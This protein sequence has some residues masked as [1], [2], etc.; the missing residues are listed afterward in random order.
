MSGES[1]EVGIDN[2]RIKTCDGKQEV[3]DPL[4]QD[5][6]LLKVIFLEAPTLPLDPDGWPDDDRW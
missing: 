4:K 6:A 3:R 1:P 2:R 5:P